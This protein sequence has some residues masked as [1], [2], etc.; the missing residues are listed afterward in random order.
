MKPIFFFI[1]CREHLDADPEQTV[2]LYSEEHQF[3]FMSQMARLLSVMHPNWLVEFGHYGYGKEGSVGEA[4]FA[5][6]EINPCEYGGYW[7]LVGDDVYILTDSAD[8]LDWV[9]TNA[10][11]S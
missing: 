8:G 10:E 1:R 2:M 3:E 7:K 6:E 4:F 11:H 5:G 9:Y